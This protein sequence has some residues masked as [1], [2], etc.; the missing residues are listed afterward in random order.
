M[1]WPIILIILVVGYVLG[2]T[3]PLRTWRHHSNQLDINS[4]MAEKA[5]ATRRRNTP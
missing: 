5:D 4:Y 3:R 2:R 1:S